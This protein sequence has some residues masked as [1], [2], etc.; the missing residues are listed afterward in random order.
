M[1]KVS[2][3]YLVCI[4]ISEDDEAV[5]QI[6]R[7]EPGSPLTVIKTIIGAEAVELHNKLTKKEIE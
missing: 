3:S 7:R 1:L 6:I 2:E 4:D 5:M